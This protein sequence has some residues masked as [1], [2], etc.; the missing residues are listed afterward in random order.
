MI[1]KII[2][3]KKKIITS[4]FLIF[5]LIISSLYFTVRQNF[6]AVVDKT[7]KLFLA[8]ISHTT[9][10]LSKFGVITLDDAVLKDEN[11]VTILYTPKLTLTYSIKDILRG[12]VIK[13]LNAEN[14]YLYIALDKERS[15]NIAKIF[16]SG[17]G[18][19]GKSGTGV[20]I[21]IITVSNARVLYQ[22]N[23]YDEPINVFVNHVDGYVSFD[24]KHGIDLRFYNTAGE[25]KIEY[26]FN[27]YEK[28]YSMD[29]KLK[30]WDIDQNIMQYA[31][32]DEYTNYLGGKAD[33]DLTL[34]SDG[35]FGTAHLSNAKFKTSAYD[36]TAE[37]INGG[38][39]FL[40][41]HLRI[42]LNGKME[43]KDVDF[44]LNYKPTSINMSVSASNLG[45]KEIKKVT[46]LDDVV[47]KKINDLGKFNI[48]YLKLNLNFDENFNLTIDNYLRVDKLKVKE[49]KLEDIK[50]RIIVK[51]SGLYLKD[52]RFY[53]NYKKNRSFTILD[54]E[55]SKNIL[56]LD[57]NVLSK[58][59]PL[60]LKKLK[61]NFKYN[62]E[63]EKIDYTLNS[64]FLN[65]GGNIDLEK[66]I[67]KISSIGTEDLKVEYEGDNYSTKNNLNV[68]YDYKN[69]ILISGHGDLE[70]KN[71]DLTKSLI[72][73]F[74]NNGSKIIFN[75]INVL[76]KELNLSAKGFL[77]T[78]DLSYNFTYQGKDFKI[79]NFMP[80]TNLETGVDF[81]G[82][83][84]GKSK[85]YSL[86]TDIKG[87]NGNFQYGEDTSNKL[88]YKNLSGRLKIINQKEFSI[89]FD[90]YLGNISSGGIE[91]SGFKVVLD[92]KNDIFRVLETRNN[93]LTIKG[94]YNIIS[95]ALNFTYKINGIQ[96]NKIK[97]LKENGIKINL[98]NI[99]GELTGTLDDFN[100][101]LQTR[102]AWI[103]YENFP[104]VYLRGGIHYLD[105]KIYFKEFKVEENNISGYFNIKDKSFNLKV[106]LLENNLA[107]YYG[108]VNVKYRLTGEIL[109]WGTPND[110][111]GIFQTYIDNLYLR[112]RKLPNLRMVSTYRG[113]K[114]DKIGESGHIDVNDIRFYSETG[115]R[116][117][118]GAGFI[119]LEKQEVSFE[120]NDTLDIE[121]L[122]AYSGTDEIKGKVKTNIK[123]QGGFNTLTYNIN[124]KSDLINIEGDDLEDLKIL[125]DGDLKKLNLKEF[126]LNYHNN[127]LISTG[128]L[129]LKTLDY[130]LDINSNEVDLSFLNVFYFSEYINKIKGIATIDIK[131]T[132]NE[133]YGEFKIKNFSAK[134]PKYGISIDKVNTEVTLEKKK[135]E[136]KYFDGKI[137]NG[138]IKMTGYLNVPSFNE[139]QKEDNK[140]FDLDYRL[141]LILDNIDYSYEDQIN[142]VLSSDAVFTNN[143]ITGEFIINSGEILGVPEVKD[144]GISSLASQIEEKK[145]IKKSKELGKKFE[146]KT[147]ET[148]TFKISIDI[149]LKTE[150]PIKVKIKSLPYTSIV[151]DI[152]GDLV[153]NGEFKVEDNELS[154]YGIVDLDDGSIKL[155]SNLFYLSTATVK[156]LKKESDALELHPLVTINANST[157]ANEEVY[158]NINGEYP[159]LEIQMSS[160][161]GLN[162]DEIGSLLT[163]HNV[164]DE[165]NS[166]VL[167]KDVIDRQVS[168]RLF[169]P[170]SSE[171]ANALRIEKFQISS[172][173]VAY[174]YEGGVYRDT[175]TLG[176]GASVE[177]ENPIYKKLYWKAK[178]R[179][180]TSKYYDSV[181]E[182]DFMVE[183]RFTK[184]LAVGTGVGKLP[185]GRVEDNESLINYHVDLTWRK[186][187]K[188]FEQM[189]LNILLLGGDK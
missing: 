48:S 170:I 123:I 82:K 106:N 118:R 97:I 23:Y 154:Y 149:D 110:I 30:N 91:F 15:V 142:L 128:S 12:K 157:I 62:L 74:T 26:S 189:M 175:G 183:H 36:G 172:D 43:G 70:I 107:E 16:S 8:D 156:F 2:K 55:Y 96:E 129:D 64:K 116:L 143:K 184:N 38:V 108:D 109:L 151:E 51:D 159:N 153:L 34:D 78:K 46:V 139:L 171:I 104:K 150:K 155:N 121:H 44:T 84:I 133:N 176:L 77:D 29:I 168:G 140:L 69:K 45:M 180:G 28:D 132:S 63:N 145:V 162:P 146:I 137:N 113:G 67:F 11:G 136:I 83:L 161:S 25:K 181:T 177:A 66:S 125:V 49:A 32:V 169:S 119:D 112:G 58:K 160:G 152:N 179:W 54:G 138:K 79:E 117:L 88:V 87:K 122:K 147:T 65:I 40:G 167:A 86:I 173:L 98:V 13:E 141:S 33:L 166:N 35:F 186:K 47:K 39:E 20:P 93:L 182:Y 60:N 57:F 18:G 127:K 99:K 19:S 126:S 4:S 94:D 80:D 120:I 17:D 124:F 114:L 27:N 81:Q 103:Q 188:S 53:M 9:S 61:G 148:D 3:H 41:D 50:G 89:D 105:G 115:E 59:A 111:N 31:Y 76:Y 73:N 185:E 90:G 134:M 22:D 7:L 42:K 68:V 100:T 144:T 92:Y 71:N 75:K 130:K 165:S 1:K 158:I 72:L 95:Q 5:I 14:P 101:K 135:V 6:D 37:D 52:V 187:Y 178:A 56:D 131:L 163:F 102:D 164:S 10:D 24:K 174:E 21:D 85:E